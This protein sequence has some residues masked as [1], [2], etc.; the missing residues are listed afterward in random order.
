MVFW[1]ISGEITYWL[2]LVL[3]REICFSRVFTFFVCFCALS[4]S[5]AQVFHIV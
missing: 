2:L 4:E 3:L 1:G 5:T